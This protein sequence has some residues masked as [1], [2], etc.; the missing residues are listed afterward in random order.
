MS[1]APNTD[2]IRREIVLPHPQEEVW[3][4]LTT[5]EI[6]AEWLHPNDF[7]ARV[8]H[9]FAFQVPA[10]PEANFPG[11]TVRSEVLELEP[12][13][14]LVLAWNAEPPVAETRISFLLEPDG[15][16]GNAT[17]LRFE[18]TGF[19][20]GHPFGKHAFKGADYGWKVLL[21]QLA[22]GLADRLKKN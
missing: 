7:E 1:D 3:E 13:R 6:L 19:D 4:A 18:H 15:P 20:L 9:R 22:A 21:D 17:R 12:R 11:L 10:K 8:G 2:T 16:E 14:K 5:R